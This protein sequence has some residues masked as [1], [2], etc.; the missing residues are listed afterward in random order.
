MVLEI[1]LYNKNETFSGWEIPG[2][3]FLVGQTASIGGSADELTD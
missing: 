1:L 3:Q 2:S